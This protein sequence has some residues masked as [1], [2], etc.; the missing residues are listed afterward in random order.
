MWEGRWVARRCVTGVLELLA[1]KYSVGL[2]LPPC[3]E[4]FSPRRQHNLLEIP[5]TDPLFHAKLVEKLHQ[6]HQACLRDLQL[7]GFALDGLDFRVS[8]FLLRG[9]QRV[10]VV[11]DVGAFVY[12]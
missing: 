5:R 12:G 8:L 4:R 6:G 1:S 2:G 10:D 11:E 3:E 9:G 7:H